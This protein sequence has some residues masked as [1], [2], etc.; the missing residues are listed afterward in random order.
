MNTLGSFT[1]RPCPPGQGL[2]GDTSG[3]SFPERQSPQL[4]ALSSNIIY[5]VMFNIP[6][7]PSPPPP[8]HPEPPIASSG[9]PQCWVSPFHT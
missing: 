1:P 2:S 7:L 3:P 4:L 9:L 8:L 6:W 5:S